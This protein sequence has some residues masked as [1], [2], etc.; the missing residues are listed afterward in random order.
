MRFWMNRMRISR[1]VR[2]IAA[3][4]AA[5]VVAYNQHR[6]FH[7]HLAHAETALAHAPPLAAQRQYPTPTGDLSAEVRLLL[8]DGSVARVRA[9]TPQSVHWRDALRAPPLASQ[10]ATLRRRPASPPARAPLRAA[11]LA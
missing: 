7:H 8:N 6:T 2:R 1:V 3:A 5:I 11:A 10:L 4:V 9:L